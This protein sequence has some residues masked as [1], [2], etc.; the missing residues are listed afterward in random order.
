[1]VKKLID[2]C[3]DNQLINEVTFK[4]KLTHFKPFK[5]LNNEDVVLLF[6][7]RDD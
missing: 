2:N 5:L 7:L 3:F 1:M 4:Q 6:I